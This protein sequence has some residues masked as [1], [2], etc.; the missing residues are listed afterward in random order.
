M[1]RLDLLP[2]AYVE[3]RRDRRNRALVV[4]AGMLVLL[5]LIGWYF[6]LRGQVSTA[7][8]ELFAV[9]AQNLQLESQI[10]ALQ[11][12][13]ALDAEV[14]SKRTALTTV[15][16][17]DIDWPA[18]LTEVAMV[19]PGDV[20]LDSL[21]ASAGVTEGS[22]P[23][24]SEANPIRLTRQPAIGRVNFG[25]N[26]T[27]CM[28]GVARWLVRLAEVEEFDAAWIGSATENDTRPGCEPPVLFD[29]TLELN[30]AA[31]SHRFEGKLE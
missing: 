2:V 30:E 28:P 24:P 8:D 21:R 13:A 14:Q 15:F 1:R 11:Q 5:L 19:V 16:A 3:R 31:L 10:A 29:S 18:V 7:N 6:M 9:Q 17:G 4:V 20:W 27:S 23:V 26:S 22:Q 25:A 12:F